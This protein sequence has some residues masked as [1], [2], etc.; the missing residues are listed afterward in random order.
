MHGL[1]RNLAIGR[2]RIK[3]KQAEY[4][5][6]QASNNEASDSLDRKNRCSLVTISVRNQNLEMIL[7]FQANF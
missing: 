6:H 7:Y 3:C 1:N 4:R 5:V 2:R